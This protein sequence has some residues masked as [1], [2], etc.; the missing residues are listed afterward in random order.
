MTLIGETNKQWLMS[1]KLLVI[2]S[3]MESYAKSLGFKDIM[4]AKSGLDNDIISA[5]LM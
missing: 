5:L 4:S 1:Q 2:S 3:R